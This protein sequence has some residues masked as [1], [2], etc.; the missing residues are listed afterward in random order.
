MLRQLNKFGTTLSLLAVLGAFPAVSSALTVS[1]DAVKTLGGVMPAGNTN[2]AGLIEYYIPLGPD[3]V[4][5][6]YTQGST[7]PSG[8]IYGDTT[9][10]CGIA[11]ICQ[12]SGDGIGYT[13][14]DALF[15]NIHFDLT[16]EPDIV[17]GTLDF[18]FV[19]LDLRDV[20]DP[21]GFFESLSLAWWDGTDLVDVTHG[22]GNET[23]YDHTDDLGDV[24]LVSAP[25]KNQD[26]LWSLDLAALGAVGVINSTD[27]LWI[28]LGFGSAYCKSHEDPLSDHCSKHG[29]NTLEYLAAELN[30]SPV[31]VPSA[32]W[33]FGSALLGFIGMSRRTRV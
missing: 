33:L 9:V 17:G 32:V 13:T 20:N 19:D 22:V 4:P 15:M 16:G 27:N 8:G 11:G 18:T 2:V 1:G 29:T 21:N 3:G 28:Q 24:G 10:P 23:V 26:L 30:V 31:P 5:V 7:P 6:G 25:G 12:D 14:A